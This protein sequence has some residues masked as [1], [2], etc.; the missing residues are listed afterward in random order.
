M[1]RNP[2]DDPPANGTAPNPMDSFGSP[3]DV[4]DEGFEVN[5]GEAESRIVPDGN[6]EAKVVEISK[7]YS[8]AGNPQWIWDFAITRGDH[9]G[10]EFRLWTA[11]T[12]SAM[13]KVAQTLDSLGVGTPG[14][15]VTFKKSDVI[16]RLC[17]IT[18]QKGSYQ[19][20]ERMS[21]QAVAPHP[22]GKGAKAQPAG[23]P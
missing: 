3:F 10:K 19:G 9:A 4:E 21:L 7:G 13:W 12:P 18:L 5:L 8:G 1:S 14:S 15:L 20:Q 22:S 23:V 6:Y 16:G 11:L 2:F 17:V